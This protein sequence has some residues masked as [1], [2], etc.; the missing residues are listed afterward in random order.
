MSDTYT[1]MI[2]IL[3][4]RLGVSEDELRP[5]T[6]FEHLGLDSLDYITLTLA[7]EGEF[8]VAIGDE[9]LGPDD[10]LSALVSLLDGRQP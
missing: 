1:R 5:A 7:L 9:E 2:A 10:T 3:T 6:T 8:G 4:E